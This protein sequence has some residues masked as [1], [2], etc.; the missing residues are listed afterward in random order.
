MERERTERERVLAQRTEG[1]AQ[2][3]KWRAAALGAVAVT[4]CALAPLLWPILS[5]L[6]K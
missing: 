3:W 6:L 2:V 5:K 1:L 4:A